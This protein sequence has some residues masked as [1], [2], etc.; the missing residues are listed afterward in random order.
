MEV[1]GLRLAAR[2]SRRTV[3]VRLPVLPL[4]SR[5]VAAQSESRTNTL[6]VGRIAQPPGWPLRLA[7]T[8]VGGTVSHQQVIA[9]VGLSNCLWAYRKNTEGDGPGNIGFA[10]GLG[11]AAADAAIDA[12][13]WF[14]TERIYDEDNTDSFG[15]PFNHNLVR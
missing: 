9:K 2:L 10:L 8:I 13:R 6:Q 14:L 12:G 11:I 1:Q 5:P 7:G 3:L 15:A 4:V